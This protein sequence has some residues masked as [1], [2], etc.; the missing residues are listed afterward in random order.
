[1]VKTMVIQIVLLQPL[2]VHIGVH[3]ST[4]QPMEDPMPQQVD[5]NIL[6]EDTA[7]GKPMLEQ[8]P[9]RSC[10]P[11]RAAHTGA[12]FLA[13]PVSCGRPTLEQ[14]VPEGLYPMDKTHT[15][16]V[17]ERPQP[18]RRTHVGAVNEGMHPVGGPSMVRSVPE[19]LYP[20]EKTHAGAVREGLQPMGRTHIGARWRGWTLRKASLMDYVNKETVSAF[21][22]HELF[23]KFMQFSW[24]D[25]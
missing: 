17:P 5:G 6:K 24:H 9:G 7:C 4:L 12:D 25:Q 18:V 22:E 8:A 15:G 19:G 14:F 13:G 11:C 1:M 20:V 3:T 23:L 2:E 16:E 10:I 21:G